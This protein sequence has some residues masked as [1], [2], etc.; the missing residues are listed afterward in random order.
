[1]KEQNNSR[2]QRLYFDDMISQ[3]QIT[4]RGMTFAYI[5]LHLYTCE[6]Y[7]PFLFLYFEIY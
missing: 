1:M 3:K 5:I 4:E 7:S 2:I 6:V